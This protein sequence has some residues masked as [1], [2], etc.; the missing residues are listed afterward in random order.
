MKSSSK[1][2]KKI[3]K[4]VEDKKWDEYKNPVLKLDKMFYQFNQKLNFKY[5]SILEKI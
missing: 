5:R 4:K 1:E 2:G 3:P